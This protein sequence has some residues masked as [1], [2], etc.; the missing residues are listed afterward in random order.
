MNSTGHTK[1]ANVQFI[2]IYT[3]YSLNTFLLMFVKT[4]ILKLD[5]SLFFKTNY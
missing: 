1:A 2:Y 4:N 5:L 3:S